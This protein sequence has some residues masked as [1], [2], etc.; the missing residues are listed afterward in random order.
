VGPG[1]AAALADDELAHLP[2]APRLA[3]AVAVMAMA[4]AFAGSAWLSW[5]LRGEAAYALTASQAIEVGALA[6]AELGPQQDGR[7]V[8][9]KVRLEGAVTLRFRRRFERD[10]YRVSRVAAGRWV[11]YRV[12]FKRAGSRFPPPELV[13]G[14]LAHADALGLRYAGLSAAIE[15][16]A[17]GE[18]GA[19]WVLVDGQGPHDSGWLLAIELML[20]GFVVWSAWSLARVLGWVR[21]RA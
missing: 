14:R 1:P 16:V 10:G 15:R 20:L 2:R 5:M 19:A 17:P 4:L 8:R 9:A 6:D 12:P 3:R 18:S 13:A 11:A 7:Y 21:P